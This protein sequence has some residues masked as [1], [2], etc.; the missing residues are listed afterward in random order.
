MRL[1]LDPFRRPLISLAGFLNQ[2]QQEV[3]YYLGR[4]SVL[5]EQLGASD[6][7]LTTTTATVDGQGQETRLG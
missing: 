2:W 7:V 6:C 1:A 4:E 3:I 5:R